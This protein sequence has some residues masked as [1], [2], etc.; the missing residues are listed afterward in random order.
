L[1]RKKTDHFVQLI[2]TSS[3]RDLT[4]DEKMQGIQLSLQD[5]RETIFEEKLQ[6]F[7]DKSYVMC[8]DLVS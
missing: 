8:Q 1:K 3:F 5:E 2:L 4:Q 6:I 7:Q